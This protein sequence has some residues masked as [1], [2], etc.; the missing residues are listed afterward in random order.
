[1]YYVQLWITFCCFF[2]ASVEKYALLLRI[3]G[4]FLF[5]FVHIYFSF[6]CFLHQLLLV[7][8]VSYLKNM[9]NY[10]NNL[11]LKPNRLSMKVSERVT[12]W[13]TLILQCVTR[14]QYK[15]FDVDDDYDVDRKWVAGAENIRKHSVLMA[16]DT[17]D[18]FHSFRLHSLRYVERKMKK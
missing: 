11:L 17:D 3:I 16:L 14:T 9:K 2:H 4:R 6:F 10:I 7:S 13:S 12:D 15:C 5:S 18:S 1:M 8:Y